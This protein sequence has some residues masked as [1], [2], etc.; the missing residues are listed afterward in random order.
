[1]K[2]NRSKALKK[3]T[4]QRNRVFARFP[5]L[6]I[7]LGTFGVISTYYGLQHILEKIPVIANNPVIAL[8]TGLVILLFTGT[9]Y[10]RLG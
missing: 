6:F 4:R 3:L 7:L 1:M 2:N 9:L 5:L 8:A 10:K